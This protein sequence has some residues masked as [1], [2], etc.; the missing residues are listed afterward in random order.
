MIISDVEKG[1]TVCHL[2]QDHIA[3]PCE[4]FVCG[5]KAECQEGPEDD[6][7]APGSFVHSRDRRWTG[8]QLARGKILLPLSRCVGSASFAST[9]DGQQGC[10]LKDF[11]RW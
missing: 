7:L 11:L 9:A 10:K 2:L 6:A 8:L 1:Q 3:G 4:F 5:R